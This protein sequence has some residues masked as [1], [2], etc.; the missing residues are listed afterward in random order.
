[1]NLEQL[2]RIKTKGRPYRIKYNRYSEVRV[3]TLKYVKW[4]ENYHNVQLEAAQRLCS[5][6]FKIASDAVGEEMV[7]AKRD[8]QIRKQLKLAI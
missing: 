3:P 7:R 5:I 1:M 4:L 8:E 6:Y 2:Y